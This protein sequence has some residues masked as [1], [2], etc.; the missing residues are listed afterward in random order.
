MQAE[1]SPAGAHPTTWI[2][3]ELRAL[4][5]AGALDL[6]IPRAGATRERWAALAEWGRRDLSLARL[7][8]GHTDAVA[9][10][11]DAGRTA[12]PTALYGVW[13]ARSGGTGARLV[14]DDG[15]LVLDGTVRF[16]SGARIL[17]RA[18]V[19]ADAPDVPDGGRLLVDL[20]VRRP[21][22]QADPDTWASAAM[23]AADTLDVRF[24]NVPVPTEAVVG[25]PGWYTARPGFAVGGA[26]VA[27][28]WWGGAAGVLDRVM[29]HLPPKPDAHQ[30]AH[31]G[32][33]HALLEAAAALLARV[34]AEV[35]GTPDA[36]HS[37]RVAAVRSA[38]ERVVREVVDR[39][40]RMV[41]PAPL[42][43]DAVLARA[44]ADLSMYVRQH[45]GERDHAALGAQVFAARRDA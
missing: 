38:T 13:A 10:L 14:R 3:P 16:C 44:L 11:A 35:D 5:A 2:E 37:R 40:P 33:L 43:R 7:A 32:E 8:E 31:V 41:G 42:S 23:A 19:V 6:P 15:A 21:G 4:L 18:L 1:S 24:E 25:G 17:D 27:A 22:I 45:H 30:L 9:I 12:D 39:A 20:A 36:D 28:V 26:G 29:G 34:A